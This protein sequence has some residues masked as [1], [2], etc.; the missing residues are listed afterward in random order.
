MY[1][2]QHQFKYAGLKIITVLG[3]LLNI[4]GSGYILMGSFLCIWLMTEVFFGVPTKP[5]K[6]APPWI[7]MIPQHCGNLIDSLYN[8]LLVGCYRSARQ[9]G[10]SIGRGGCVQWPLLSP[11]GQTQGRRWQPHQTLHCGEEWRCQGYLGGGMHHWG[12][13]DWRDRTEGG[14]PLPVPGQ[15]C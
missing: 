6:I 13:G 7:L 1:Y 11:V 4:L 14:T 9:T 10:G 3:N 2:F 5:A 8:N 12:S 15:G